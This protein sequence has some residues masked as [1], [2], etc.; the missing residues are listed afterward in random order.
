[1][2][3]QAPTSKLQRSS[4]LQPPTARMRLFG[5]W[6]MRFLWMVELGIWTFDL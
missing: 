5:A 1:M 6:S 2:K 3:H 4:K